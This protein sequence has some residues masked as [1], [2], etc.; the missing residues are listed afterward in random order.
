MKQS[1][2]EVEAAALRYVIVQLHVAL[3][4]CRKLLCG[5][6]APMGGCTGQVSP[7]WIL[8][9]ISMTRQGAIERLLVKGSMRVFKG[10]RGKATL[11]FFFQRCKRWRYVHGAQLPPPGNPCSRLTSAI[12]TCRLTDRSQAA[13]FLYFCNLTTNTVAVKNSIKSY[14]NV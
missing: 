4:V 3:P 6:S 2:Y 12:G 10:V 9:G 7:R 8:L 13:T 14:D 11:A 5:V 1:M